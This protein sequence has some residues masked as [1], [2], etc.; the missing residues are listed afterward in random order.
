MSIIGVDINLRVVSACRIDRNGVTQQDWRVAPLPSLECARYI[1]AS[2]RKD[3]LATGS[4]VVWIERPMGVHIKSVADL[5]RV[6]GGFIA[7]ARRP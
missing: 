6:M 1:A 5:S 4:D 7:P 2:V 3:P